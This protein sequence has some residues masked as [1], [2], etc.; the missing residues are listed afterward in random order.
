[1]ETLT[2]LIEEDFSHMDIEQWFNISQNVI[3]GLMA[4]FTAVWTFR[5]FAHKDKILELKHLMSALSGLETA[6]DNFSNLS[7]N[8]DEIDGDK[9]LRCMLEL[10]DSARNCLYVSTEDYF[11][12]QKQIVDILGIATKTALAES[13][14]EREKLKTE[15][16]LPLQVKLMSKIL[17]LSKK[18]TYVK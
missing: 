1:M 5:T 13:K 17:D 11:E 6:L 4:I 10:R 18:Y 16:Y 14:Q 8:S 2:I 3:I 7:N 15:K 9:I 12:F